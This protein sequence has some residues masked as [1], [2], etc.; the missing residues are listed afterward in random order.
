MKHQVQDGEILNKTVQYKPTLPAARI[1][2]TRLN[3]SDAPI[4]KRKKKKKEKQRKEEKPTRPT[5]RAEVVYDRR[6]VGF[7]LAI[8][9][10]PF[11]SDSF[12]GGCSLCGYVLPV[13]LVSNC[14]FRDFAVFQPLPFSASPLVARNDPF[15]RTA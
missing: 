4:Q 11:R 8:A 5:G 13:F 2:M 12:F 10:P 15:S 14:F 1:I 7:F 3:K 9:H 6:Y